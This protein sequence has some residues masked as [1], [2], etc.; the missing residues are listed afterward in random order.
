MNEIVKIDGKDWPVTEW[1]AQR[2]I[3]TVQ[4]A[5]IYE[6]SETQVKQNFNNNKVNFTEKTHFFYLQGDEL[7][8]FKR[9]VDN[10]DLPQAETLKFVS[11]LYLWTRQG[12]SRHC[13]ILGTKRA[14]EQFDV[15]EESYYNPRPQLSVDSVEQLIDNPDFGIKL[16]TALK[17]KKEENEK[18]HAKVK[19]KE[20]R[21]IEMRPKEICADA[22]TASHTS[23]LVG[24]LAKLMKQNGVEIGA[25]RLFIWLRDNGYL[26][27]RKGSDWNMPTQKSME[28]GLFEIKESTHLD[29]NGCNVTTRTPKVT[30]K[31]QQYFINKFLD[32][33]ET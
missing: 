11:H 21:I 14:W 33:E 25:R 18:L 22:V 27:K 16:L 20:A 6:A 3:T 19:E 24:D 17:E 31:G 26:I 23:I 1:R 29:G 7:K 15:L 5:E 28:A 2:V 13:K 4:L 32:K 12:A 8:A 9:Q 10:I 30:G